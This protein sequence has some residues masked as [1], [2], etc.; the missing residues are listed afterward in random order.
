MWM[1]YYSRTASATVTVERRAA[2]ATV[3]MSVQSVVTC[4]THTQDT[5]RVPE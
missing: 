4:A 2:T 5:A 1:Y 3:D